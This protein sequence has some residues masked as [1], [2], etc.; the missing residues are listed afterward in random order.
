MSTRGATHVLRL[1]WTLADLAGRHRP[2]PYERTEAITLL[3]PPA[4]HSTEHR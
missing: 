2:G 3:G 1:A 4:T